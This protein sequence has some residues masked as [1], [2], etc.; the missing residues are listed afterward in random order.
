M[1][2]IFRPWIGEQYFSQSPKIL[3][4]GESHYLNQNER[5]IENF[6][7]RVVRDLRLPGNKKFD[8]LQLLL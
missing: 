6:T 1:P 4:L 2:V 8:F 3:V 5:D 7:I